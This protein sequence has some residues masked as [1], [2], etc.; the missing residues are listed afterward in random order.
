MTDPIAR[1]FDAFSL[2]NFVREDDWR[3]RTQF[4]ALATQRQWD[5][6]RREREYRQ[7][8]RA[9]TEL[10]EEEFGGE[11]T[12]ENYQALCE[13]LGIDPPPD[14]IRGCKEELKKVHVNI[15]D[16]MQARWN[17]RMGRPAGHVPTFDTAA[18]AKAYAA[19]ENKY[20]PIEGARG[21]VLRA[22]LRY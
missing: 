16:L 19:Q 4:N 13:E 9:W 10:V 14:T 18:E 8:K 21:E 17:I 22:L 3:Q 11:K 1:Y 7:L 2:F 6:A 12:L 5:Q 15:I 20:Y